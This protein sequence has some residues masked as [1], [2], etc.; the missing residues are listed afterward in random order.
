MAELA[1]HDCSDLGSSPRW[2]KRNNMKT[3]RFFSTQ[4]IPADKENFFNTV[5]FDISNETVEAAYEEAKALVAEG[6]KVWTWYEIKPTY[7][8]GTV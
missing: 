4:R 2:P 7:N 8:D 5:F 1:A 6:H 3:F